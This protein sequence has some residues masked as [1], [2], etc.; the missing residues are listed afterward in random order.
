MTHEGLE[1]LHSAPDATKRPIVVGTDVPAVSRGSAIRLFFCCRVVFGCGQTIGDGWG[2]PTPTCA[3]GSTTQNDVGPDR[4]LRARACR[5]RQGPQASPGT[6]DQTFRHMSVRRAYGGCFRAS[7][8]LMQHLPNPCI[9]ART[10]TSSSANRSGRTLASRP[11]ADSPVLAGA[12]A[13]SRRN[14]EAAPGGGSAP[15]RAGG[16]AGRVEEGDRLA[17]VRYSVVA[18]RPVAIP[19]R[20]SALAGGGA[21]A[22]SLAA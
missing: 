15:L 18:D 20:R 14:D 10:P 12:R 22:R 16:P 4:R 5:P 13:V 11:F 19:R 8:R 2:R 7:A 21:S 1:W 3:I 6:A 17:G 9:P